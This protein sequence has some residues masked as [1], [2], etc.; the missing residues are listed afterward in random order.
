MPIRKRICSE[1]SDLPELWS[2]SVRATYALLSAADID[3]ISPEVAGQLPAV[4]AWV[5]EADVSPVRTAITSK[6]HLS[7]P[8]RAVGTHFWIMYAIELRRSTV[9]VNAQ[10]FEAHRF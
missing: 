7:S 10:D 2:R 1:N 6:C 3:A 4:D 8:R 9:E 5:F